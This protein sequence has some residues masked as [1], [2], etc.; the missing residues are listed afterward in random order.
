MYGKP[1]GGSRIRNSSLP[2]SGFLPP[3]PLPASFDG[4]S[5]TL[6]STCVPFHSNLMSFGPHFLSEENCFRLTWKLLSKASVVGPSNTSLGT[7][8]GS[9]VST[10][11]SAP[12]AGSDP[13]GSSMPAAPASAVPSGPTTCGCM[14]TSAGPCAP[15]PPATGR[16]FCSAPWEA[17]LTFRTLVASISKVAATASRSGSSKSA[18]WVSTAWLKASVSS[19]VRRK[20]WAFSRSPTKSEAHWRFS[21]PGSYKG[22]MKGACRKSSPCA[23][24]A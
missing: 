22:F 18:T 17:G 15:P 7:G 5:D 11:S 21:C 24:P 2:D 19:E 4:L 3:A 16:R 10:E 8:G 23:D 6:A 14:S 13:G 12:A 20:L 9:L 1:S